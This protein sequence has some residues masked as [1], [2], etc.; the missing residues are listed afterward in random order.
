MKELVSYTAKKKWDIK[1]GCGNH[2]IIVRAPECSYA[3]VLLPWRRHDDVSE[4]GIR[5]FRG[6]KEIH[7]I[8]MLES[9]EDYG[10]IVFEAAEPGNYE[11]Y[12]M[13]CTIHGEW[14]DPFVT[15]FKKSEMQPAKNW[16]KGY[17]E[18]KSKEAKAL[19]YECRTEFDSFYPMEICMTKSEQD[20]FLS[21]FKGD[22]VITESRFFPVR[23]TKKLPTKWNTRTKEDCL[24][25]SDEV[26]DN[27][28]YVFQINVFSKYGTENVLPKFSEYS[29][30]LTCFNKATDIPAGTLQT[31][32]CGVRC[33]KYRTCKIHFTVEVCGET[34][35]VCLLKNGEKIIRNGD[36]DPK[37]M[38]RLF[39]F[40]SD[41]GTKTSPTKEFSNKGITFV[42]G[43]LD[44]PKQ[45]TSCYDDFIQLSDMRTDILAAPVRFIAGKDAKLR[46]KI[47]YEPDGNV[48][49]EISVIRNSC[50][51]EDFS[52]EIP[53]KPEVATYMVGM[54][55][56]GGKTPD[57]WRYDFSTK[58]QGY[59]VWLGR[60]NAGLQ[61]KLMGEKEDW[62]FYKRIPE[63]W[64][65]NGKGYI[66]L[67]KSRDCVLL[68]THVKSKEKNLKFHFHLTVTPFK[69]ID[70][71][72]HFTEH[73]YHESGWGLEESFEYL[74][75]AINAKADTIILHQGGILNENINYPF[76][77]TEN[78]KKHVDKAHSL[79]LKYKL[80]YTCRELSTRL[81][82]LWALRSFNDEMFIT[83][84]TFPLA[85]YFARDKSKDWPG[86]GTPW[87]YEH[88][89][90]NWNSAWNQ[91]LHDG[92]FDTAV[93]MKTCSRWN[94]YYLTGLDWLT[95]VAGIDGIY[96]DGMNYDRH[97]M[98]RVYNILM[99][100]RGYA[101]IDIHCGNEHTDP[102][103]G[104]GAS[105]CNYM[106]HYA[107]VKSIWNGEGFDYFGHG[108]DYY[109]TEICGIPFGVMGEMLQGGGHPYRGMLYGMTARAGWQ[110]GGIS[111]PLFELWDKFN[112]KTSKMYGYWH[113]DCPVSTDCE[114]VK[115]TSY[116]KKNGEILIALASWESSDREI[117]LS[118]RNNVKNFV[119]YAPEIDGLQ[120]EEKYEVG[121]KIPIAS[122]SGKI[123]ILKK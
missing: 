44:L 91:Y 40:D 86:R 5:I 6:K 16:L 38:S 119:L 105:V 52:L 62:G 10:V 18:N 73:Y 26:Y 109:F 88:L 34:V 104:G 56:E 85:D 7:N 28:H 45:I 35:S 90:G 42:K 51:S 97:I 30:R 46:S 21:K 23:L 113:P 89:D 82:E 81:P 8:L 76:L 102:C 48:D 53:F 117:T 4:K 64:S 93:A 32:W 123:L 25:L 121:D 122:V 27:E 22:A 103:Y 111:T 70:Y 72:A 47:T 101:D 39:W 1:N 107:Y 15:Y 84:G 36:D 96:V 50:K 110:Q 9:N 19:R 11:I 78:L 29:E 33:E 98:R 108:P 100:N 67:K 106:E 43:K 66:E 31:F 112:I 115:A 17:K 71:K 116:T 14:Y 83:D 120:S 13:P 94:N 114:N 61:L 65:G 118:F 74:D 69:P 57:K 95:K 87:L 24:T 12:Y 59:I 2:R 49:C 54:L 20:N 55:R 37:R 80:Y 77:N 99:K 68:S 75:K 3:K 58:L 63:P 79:G 41:I 92:E 60:H